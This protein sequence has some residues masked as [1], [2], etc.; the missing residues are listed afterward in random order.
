MT[1]S[2]RMKEYE[3]NSQF[4]L[5]RKLPVIVRIDGRSFHTFTSE[6]SKPFDASITMSMIDTTEYL[7]KNVQNAKLG[8]TQSDE[9]T[10]LL[11]DWDKDNTDSFF[12]YK[13]QK[14]VSVISSMATMHFNRCFVEYQ[15]M[16]GY[17]DIKRGNAIFDTRSFNVPLHEVINVFIWRQQDAIRNS[18]QSIARS[19]FSH[20]EVMGKK[21][22]QL[23]SMINTTDKT[24]EEYPIFLKRGTCVKKLKEN[25]DWV[26]DLE[27]PIFSEN[28]KY[29][30]EV[31]YE[32]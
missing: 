18:M 16:Y 32:S 3:S 29:I 25:S 27:I 21:I 2:D 7:C 6:L 30:T 14:L 22:D 4:K 8:Y 9:I 24:W 26:A 17:T 20:K 11:T 13:L 31:L 10:L 19:K 12:G 1:L 23:K 28:K 15:K 5:I